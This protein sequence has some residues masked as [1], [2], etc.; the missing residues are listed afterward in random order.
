MIGKTIL[1][2]VLAAAQTESGWDAERVKALR[3]RVDGKTAEAV[4]VLEAAM[5]QYPREAG[6]PYELADALLDQV[7]ADAIAGASSATRVPRLERVVTLL[8][9]AMSLDTQYLQIG[10][11]KLLTVYEEDGFERPA[12]VERL[13]R[14]LMTRDP[15]SGIWAIKL[16]Q[17]LA[18]QQRCGEAARA[19][20]TAQKNV[21]PDRRL[22]FGMSMTDL[23]VKCPTMPLADARPL[24]EAAGAIATEALKSTPDDRDVL[25]FQGATLTALAS[26]LPD[27]PEKKALEERGAQ[28]A[29]RFMDL[30]PRRQ[31]AMRGEAPDVIYDGFS[32]VNEFLDDGKTAEAEK[33]LA[34][35]AVKHA[36]SAEFW[37]TATFVQQRRGKRD[38]ALAAAKRHVELSPPGPEPHLLLGN[39]YAMWAL[40]EAAPPKQRLTDLA[41]A[42]AAYEAALKIDPNDIGGLI[43][44][45]DA[46]KTRAALEQDPARKQAL[47]AEARTWSAR[48][49][50]AI[51]AKP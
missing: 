30:N 43:G 38:E 49:G 50:E 24:L 2:A 28:V 6:A 47:L 23:F 9:R 33:L 10:A 17:S 42:Q 21:E 48:A 35:M 45:A 44:K 36:K 22:L 18:A 14:D 34:S 37:S 20:V 31:A 27:G 39:L 41:S 26:A 19:M 25:M 5:K 12:E 3:L 7:R 51:K 1:F 11:A 40:D 32:Y 29:S 4:T 16:A 13:S 15:A 8:R 46:L